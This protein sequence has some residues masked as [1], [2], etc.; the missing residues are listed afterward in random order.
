MESQPSPSLP[1]LLGSYGTALT[2]GGIA[3]IVAPGWAN[4][5][6]TGV[7]SVFVEHLA[8]SRGASV[9]ALGVIALTAIRQAGRHRSLLPGLALSSAL[10]GCLQLLVQ[11]SPQAAAGRWV[12]VLL[13]AVWATGLA[14]HGSGTVHSTAMTTAKTPRPITP[15]YLLVVS[16]GLWTGI[17]GLLW[18]VAPGPL[19]A[20]LE[21]MA[22][23]GA[24]YFAAARGAVDL[25]LGWL[26][27]TIRDRIRSGTSW[28]VIVGMLVANII[29]S[30]A[31]LIAQL[32]SIAT[33]SRWAVELLHIGW[34]IGAGWLVCGLWKTRSVA[35][36]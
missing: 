14:W 15:A 28:A 21:T 2:A 11:L 22:G 5:M 7:S 24:G 26:A 3:L 12:A 36:I 20:Q 1:W 6:E 31:G 34:T 33:P 35:T 9:L 4:R 10:L 27:W 19:G 16:F 23:P 17:T 29:L 30:A 18:L 13:L 25:P 8:Q 32:E